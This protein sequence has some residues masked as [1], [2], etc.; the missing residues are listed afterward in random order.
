MRGDDK[1]NMKKSGDM[2]GQGARVVTDMWIVNSSISKYLFVGLMKQR[3]YWISSQI[4]RS[5]SMIVKI[6]IKTIYFRKYF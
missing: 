2:P 5:F 4:T 3:I 1:S 6:F